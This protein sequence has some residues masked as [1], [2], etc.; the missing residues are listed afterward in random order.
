[1]EGGPGMSELAGLAGFDGLGEDCVAII[2]VEH[3]DIIVATGRLD[4]KFSGLIRVAGGEKGSKNDMGAGIVA[5]LGGLN[6]KRCGN[7]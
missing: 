3:H 6:I 1:M 2:V 4:W 7:G 5:L